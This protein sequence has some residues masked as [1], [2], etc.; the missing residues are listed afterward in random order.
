MKTI[1]EKIIKNIPNLKKKLKPNDYST[2]CC[3]LSFQV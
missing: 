3:V 2:R 1:V